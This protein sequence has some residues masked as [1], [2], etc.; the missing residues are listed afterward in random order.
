MKKNNHTITYCEY[1]SID[2]LCENDRE[3]LLIAREASNNAY[4]PYSKFCVGAA[5]KLTNDTIVIG[6]NQENSAY[7]SGLCAERVAMFSASAKYPGILIDKIA[8]TSKSEKFLVDTPTFPCGACRQVLSEY[9]NLY[10]KKI[11]IIFLAF[12]YNV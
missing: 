4:A 9:E 2:E 10:D 6:N 5:I 12:I 3:L 11:K 1:D 8:I 7:P